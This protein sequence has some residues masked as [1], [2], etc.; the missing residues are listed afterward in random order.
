MKTYNADE[1]S[2]IFGGIPISGGF[3]D[4]EFL[5]IEQNEE[6][7]QTVVG[8]DGEVTRSKTNNKTARVTIIL[9][10]SSTFNAALSA[11]HEA[12]KITPGGTGVVPL[13]VKNN[14]GLDLYTAK[15]AWIVQAP[16]AS[17]DR[18][19]TPREWVV[20]CANLI[21]VDGGQL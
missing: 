21:R 6:A 19:A 17:F 2:I 12:D 5:R 4:G 16:D 18:T 3:A 9:M 10:Q 14:N 15:D 13:L 20:E 1:V 8:T 11:L 7:F